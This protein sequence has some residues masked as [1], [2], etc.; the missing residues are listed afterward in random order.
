MSL[1]LAGRPAATKH[2]HNSVVR[3]RGAA[4]EFCN[5]RLPR[6]HPAGNRRPGNSLDSGGAAEADAFRSTTLAEADAQAAR[7]RADAAAHAERS[8]AEAQPAPAAAAKASPARP[9][10]IR[11]GRLASA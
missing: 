3:P 11:S 2:P 7:V 9:E 6:G 1:R 8:T 4:A 5:V 10:R